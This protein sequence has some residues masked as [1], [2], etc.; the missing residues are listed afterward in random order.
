MPT[1]NE[2]S[3]HT[4]EADSPSLAHRAFDWP[5]VGPHYITSWSVILGP[6]A[7]PG[8]LLE[9]QVFGPAPELLM[10]KLEMGSPGDS[11]RC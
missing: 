2:L 10:Q 7:T 5:A 3:L 4:R 11:E 1:R 8:S 9:M 6:A